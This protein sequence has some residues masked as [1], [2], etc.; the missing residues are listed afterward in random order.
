MEKKEIIDILEELKEIQKLIE[1]KENKENN[2]LEK[3]EIEFEKRAKEDKK[4]AKII[5]LEYGLKNNIDRI[6]KNSEEATIKTLKS[7]IKQKR[8]KISSMTDCL[9]GALGVCYELT[10]YKKFVNDKKAQQKMIKFL[11]D[12]IEAYEL[13]IKKEK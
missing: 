9:N 12:I 1:K 6:L 3:F 11:K 4:L 5:Y 7:G 8:T 2:G 10:S 13:T